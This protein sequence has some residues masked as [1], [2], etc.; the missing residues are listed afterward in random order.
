MSDKPSAP[1]KPAPESEA[2]PSRTL[3]Y[4]AANPKQGSGKSKTGS[5]SK[6][7]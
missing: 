2:K 5:K 7:D 4:G 6:D 1:S 3:S